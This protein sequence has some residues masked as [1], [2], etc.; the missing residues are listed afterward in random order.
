MVNRRKTGEALLQEDGQQVGQARAGKAH[1]KKRFAAGADMRRD[2]LPDRGVLAM[3][4]Q[5]FL[6]RGILRL[7]D[8]SETA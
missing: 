8:P 5:Q 6:R 2:R 1:E 7:V 4:D 3:V